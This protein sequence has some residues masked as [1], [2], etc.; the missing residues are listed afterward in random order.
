MSRT[1]KQVFSK[2]HNC[3]DRRSSIDYDY[4]HKLSQEEKE[5]LAK[6]SDEYYSASFKINPTYVKYRDCIKTLKYMI[7]IE[8][9]PKKLVKFQNQLE[10]YKTLKE[11]KFVQIS[12]R[13]NRRENLD[14]R[15]FRSV[16]KYYK[17]TDNEL[18]SDETLK[19]CSSNIHPTPPKR[20]SCNQNVNSSQRDLMSVGFQDRHI[21]DSGIDI[22]V[23]EHSVPEVDHE[24]KMI[25]DEEIKERIRIKEILKD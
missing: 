8:K 9:N 21:A 12:D 20:S 6:F 10:Y 19:Y 22:I 7:S 4:I 16:K 3:K 1:P 24:A 11:E 23:E 17:N 5:W 25:F 13:Q 15:K 18:K 14:L 2:S